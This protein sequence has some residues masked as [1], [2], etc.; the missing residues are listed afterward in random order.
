MTTILYTSGVLATDSSLIEGG[1]L[2]GQV[3]KLLELEGRYFATC[4]YFA[5]GLQYARMLSRSKKDST[6]FELS[7]D[8]CVVELLTTS[9]LRVYE[10]GSYYDISPDTVLGFGTGGPLAHACILAGADITPAMRA[11]ARIDP[12]SS[13]PFQAVRYDHANKEFVRWEFK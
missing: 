6:P 1:W 9:H 10:L 5:E 2:A 3:S 12:G 8:T 13:G 11:T 4:G 7:K